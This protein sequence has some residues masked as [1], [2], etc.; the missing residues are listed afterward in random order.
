MITYPHAKINL[1][2]HIL[3]KRVDGFHDLETLFYPI[4]LRDI[5]EIIPSP[6]L[7][8]PRLTVSGI[9]IEGHADNNL[10]LQAY[11]LLHNDFPNLD[12]VSIHLHKQIPTQ[13]GLGGGSADASFTLRSLNSIFKLGLSSEDLRSYAAR[14]GSDCSF[15]IDS[16]PSIGSGKGD[17][18]T[19]FPISLKGY[20]LLV[21][22]PS[23]KIST[24][25]AY[26]NT[27]PHIPNLSLQEI[28]A[29][30]IQDWKNLL[31]NDF[32]S[33][34]FPRYPILADIKSCCYKHGALYA[35]LSGSGSAMYGVFPSSPT[36]SPFRSLGNPQ[37]YCEELS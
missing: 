3:R 30:P 9:E 1:G 11:R 34:L 29:H 35:S 20:Y 23:L 12:P 15:F 2:L 10:C 4:D 24:A 26:A 36:L 27:T 8:Y 32:E 33:S 7:P 5:L 22:V 18:L 13:A 17:I 6:E 25:E 31:N 28:L 37:L 19:P 16:N 14:L 21:I